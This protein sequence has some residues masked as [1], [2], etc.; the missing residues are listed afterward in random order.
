MEQRTDD[1]HKARNG[2]LTGSRFAALM[3]SGKTREDLIK[4]LAWMRFTGEPLESYSNAAMQRGIE[5][6]PEARDWYVFQSGNRVDEEGF[7]AHASIPYV[8]ISP[9]GLVGEDGLIEI[10]APLHRGHI[11][12]IERKKMPSQYRWQVQGQL[13]VTGRKWLDYVS[14]HPDHG[15]IIIRIEPSMADHEKLEEACIQ[16]NIEIEG[17]VSL[18]NEGKT[19]GT[20]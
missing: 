17:L 13:W 3:S 5:L 18:L 4:D 9:D 12:T 16:A 2:C 6:E 7:I 15:G 10:K 8:G 1:W 11:E 20:D 14:Y 19:R